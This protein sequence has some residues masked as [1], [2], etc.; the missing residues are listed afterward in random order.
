MG[1]F[2]R[3]DARE[4]SGKPEEVQALLKRP[5]NGPRRRSVARDDEDDYKALA[6]N[7]NFEREEQRT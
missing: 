6:P 5:R 1:E 7:G 4:L 3:R 2:C